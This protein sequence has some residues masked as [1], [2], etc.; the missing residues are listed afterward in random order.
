MLDQAVHERPRRVA[1]PRMDDEPRRLVDDQQVLVLPGHAQVHGLG[2]ERSCV[3]RELDEDVL[4]ALE[5]MALR[6]GLAV[7]EDR[8]ARDQALGERA[9]AH[10]RPAGEGAVEA[11]GLRG[12]KAESG[13]LGEAGALLGRNRREP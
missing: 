3:R 11:L 4:P 7:D 6:P 1:D 13:Q 12:A 10:F 9:R 5:A 2:L 8:P